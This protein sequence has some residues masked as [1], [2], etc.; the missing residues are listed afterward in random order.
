VTGTPAKITLLPLVAAIF[1]M[2]CGG[3]FGLEDIVSKCGYSGAILIL[4]LTP[5]LWSFPTVL[6]VSELSSAV[7]EEGG[8]YVWVR[9]ALGPFWGYQEAW[10][11]LVGSIFDMAIYPTLFVEYLG[12]FAPGATA[13]WRGIAIGWALIAATASWNLL[14]AKRV[15]G[16]SVVMG[17]VLLAPF[18]TLAVLAAFHGHA[19]SPGA[20]IPL[21]N[22]DLLGGILVAMWNYMGWDYSST[23]A[24]EVENPQRTYPRAM[25]TAV[26]LVGLTYVLPVAAVAATS[27][28]ANQWSTGGWANVA[29]ALSSSRGAGAI[30][31]ASITAGAMLS[32]AG[33]LNALTLSYSRVPF[34]MAEDGLLPPAFTRL[35]RS[36]APWV[37]IVACS[38]MWA[39]CLGMSFVKLVLLDVL[40]TGSSLLLEFAALVALRI[41]EPRLSRPYR[42]PGGLFGAIS[43]GLPPLVLMIL[44]AVRNAQDRVGPVNALAF[45][46]ILVLAGVCA[47]FASVRLFQRTPR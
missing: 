47:Y 14:G 20:A 32:N 10:L 44:T 8:Y 46:G 35:N 40:L 7:P 30:I 6:M 39:M 12:H 13:G 22:V 41:R 25:A 36:G 17:I 2:V 11:S 37:A 29:T 34:A 43:V 18:L 9:R 42:V 1:F 4:L 31:A 15:G 3:P 24:G 27:L 16:S 28:D 21:R 5:A 23:V 45:G 19:G 26:V 33:M 38:A